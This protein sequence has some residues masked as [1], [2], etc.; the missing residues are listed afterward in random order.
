MN[1]S[2]VRLAITQSELFNSWPDE[3]IARLIQSADVLVV[4]PGA[5]VLRSGDTASYLLLVV[6]GSMNLSR[7]MPSGRSFT[8][9]LHFAGDFHGLGPA[10]AQKPHIYTAICKE[11]TVLVRI[12]ADLLRNMVAANGR[13]SF[14]LFAALDGRYIKALD[15]HASA[16][17]NSTQAR[18][19][20]L[21]QSIEARSGRGRSNPEINLSQDEIATML[22]TRRQV[23]NRVLHDMATAGAIHLHYGRISI[24]DHEK[25]SQMALEVQ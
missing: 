16:A 12:P 1:K 14:S 9:G 15:L 22:G 7:D 25:L 20:S 10:I 24:V 5:C 2:L 13:F 17:A 21:L 11:R 18:I 8:A 6:S 19:A 4:E 23:V 3:A